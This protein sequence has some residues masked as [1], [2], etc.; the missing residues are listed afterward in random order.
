MIN[1]RSARSPNAGNARRSTS[2]NAEVGKT[3]FTWWA[4]AEMR[5]KKANAGKRSVPSRSPYQYP[6]AAGEGAS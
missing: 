5:E 6:L 2:D 3:F 1:M 4:T